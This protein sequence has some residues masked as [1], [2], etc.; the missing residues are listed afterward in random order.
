MY[1]TKIVQDESHYSHNRMIRTLF[2][3]MCQFT[4]HNHTTQN[5]KM[6]YFPHFCH[7]LI[8]Y[9]HNFVSLQTLEEKAVIKIEVNKFKPIILKI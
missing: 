6:N 8:Q 7:I 1:D 3:H 5:N 9:H 2:L 4:D